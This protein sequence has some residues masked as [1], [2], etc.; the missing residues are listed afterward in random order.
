MHTNPGEYGKVVDAGFDFLTL[1]TTPRRSDYHDFQSVAL[2]FLD[3]M[4]KAGVEVV[5][6]RFDAYEGFKAGDTY[7]G[8]REDSCIWKTSGGLSRNVAQFCKAHQASFHSTRADLQLTF[9]PNEGIVRGL[10][11]LLRGLRGI[12]VGDTPVKRN[13]SA[14]FYT[15]DVCTGFTLGDRSSETYLRVYLAGLKHPERYSPNAV[16]FEAEWKGG[17]ADQIMHA[18]TNAVDD[19]TLSGAYVSGEFL[20]Y[21]IK[22]PMQALLEPCKLPGLKRSSS[23]EKTLNWLTGFVCR[24]IEKMVLKGYGKEL[25]G[26]ILR[27]LTPEPEERRTSGALEKE[28]SKNPLRID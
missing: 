8:K 16:R 6:Q 17:R 24:V 12:D 22:E 26:P 5:E 10:G 15:T 4:Q 19:V 13:K 20:K 27:A 9:E 18:F 28:C 11:E 7:Y 21:G 1:T 14:T 25:R 2:A 3:G 23:D